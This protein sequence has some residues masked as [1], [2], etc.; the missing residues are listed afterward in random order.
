MA[1]ESTPK[2]T[3]TVVNVDGKRVKRPV[4]QSARK[5]PSKAFI[6]KCAEIRGFMTGNEKTS[7]KTLEVKNAWQ[8]INNRSM[9]DDVTVNFTSVEND[10]LQ[11]LMREFVAGVN[12]VL[13]T[14]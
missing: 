5:R 2:Q 1:N 4:Q 11:R 14:K 7:L 9:S 3:K 13:K 8:K 12:K 6:T 10:E